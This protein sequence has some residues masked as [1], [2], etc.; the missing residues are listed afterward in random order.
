MTIGATAPL[1]IDVEREK[2][3]SNPDTYNPQFTYTDEEAALRAARTVK[4]SGVLAGMAERVLEGVLQRHGSESGYHQAVWGEVL[5]RD[6]ADEMVSDYLFQNGMD[7]L[8]RVVWSRKS[9]VTNFSH[10]TA[11]QRFAGTLRLVAREGYYRRERLRGLL[12]HELG[13]HMTRAFNHRA[14]SPPWSL[15][16]PPYF[17]SLASEEGL[18]SLNTHQYLADT[19]LFQP[20]LLYWSCHQASGAS[21]CELGRRMR[22]F[23][24]DPSRVWL[25]CVRAKRGLTDTSLPGG[26][27]KDQSTFDGIVRLLRFRGRLDPTVLHSCK[28]SLET[29]EEAQRAAS[30]RGGGGGG[31]GR[32][33]RAL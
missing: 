20:A 8:V 16:K 1:N 7:G 2:W 30:R 27:A 25:E 33:C 22:R 4:A 19:S 24:D 31:G 13:T 14:S 18:A 10:N 23:V 6:E 32:S 12:D 5:T 29:Y 21:F 15:P 3:L 28:V 26:L 11:K 9:L 17:L